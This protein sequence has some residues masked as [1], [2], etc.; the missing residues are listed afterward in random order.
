M[1][2]QQEKKIRVPDEIAT[3]MRHFHPRLKAGVK[4]ALRDILEDPACGKAL[5][6]E[7]EGLRSYRVKR[8]RIIYRVGG[9]FIEI[10]AVGPRRVIYQE[11]FRLIRKE[12]G[13]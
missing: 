8:F 2:P 6:D 3:L 5:K 4:A 7:L 11:T 1:T 9:K 13:K 10:V 12:K